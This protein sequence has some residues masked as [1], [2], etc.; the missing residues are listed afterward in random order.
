MDNDETLRNAL[1]KITAFALLMRNLP[2][3]SAIDAHAVGE[4]LGQCAGEVVAALGLAG[5]EALVK[6]A[7]D[8]VRSL[9]SQLGMISLEDEAW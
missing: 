5:D 6:L 8:T 4:G 2:P 7:C 9:R 1:A 3:G